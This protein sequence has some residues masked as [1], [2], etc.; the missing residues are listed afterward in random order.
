[1]D[2]LPSFAETGAS[3]TTDDYK[4]LEF[5]ALKCYPHSKLVSRNFSSFLFAAL[6]RL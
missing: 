1:M 2:A 6:T 4:F 3:M 5:L